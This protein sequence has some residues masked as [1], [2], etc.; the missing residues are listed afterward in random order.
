M[1]HGQVEEGS[2]EAI[3]EDGAEGEVQVVA[4]VEPGDDDIRS[5]VRIITR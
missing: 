2:G 4:I 3:A 1:E 5:R